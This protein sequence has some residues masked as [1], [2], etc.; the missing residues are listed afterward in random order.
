MKNLFSSLVILCCSLSI[1]A[2]E[3]PS[4]ILFIYDASGSMW[5]AMENKTKKEIASD[6]LISTVGNLPDNQNIGLIAYGHRKKSDCDDIEYLVN[7]TNNTKS[8]VTNAVK[9]LNPTG[10]TPLARSATLAINSLKESNTKATIILITDGKESCDGDICN[11]ITDAKAN[12][13]DFK[14]H[15]VGF[16]LKEGEKEQ[17]KCAALAGNGKYYDADNAGGL[18]DVLTEATTETVDKPKG[19]FSVYAVKNGEPV[20]AWVKPQNSETKKDL[21]GARTYRDTAWVYL[22]T[23]KYD[24]EVKPLENSDIPSTTISVEIKEGEMKH[25]DVSFDGGILE[26]STTTNGEP[27]DAIVKMYDKNTGKVIANAR[28]YGRSKQMEVPAGNYKVTYQA[29]N[30]EGIDIYV[31]VNDVEVQANTTNSISHD[32]KSGIVMIGVKTASGELIDATV[33]F[34]EINT[35]KNVAG[36]RTYTSDSSNPKKFILNPGTYEVKISTVG[37]HKGY[38]DSFTIIVEEGKTVE[39]SITF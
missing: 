4:P 7:L 38:K 25:K 35:R 34:H 15:I 8:N 19:N 11:V 23:G 26:V 37:K 30:L 39:K 33:N 18:G 24:I 32:F 10:R 1:N 28:T 12:G 6:V 13:I 36:A 31:E 16:G 5:G 29:L 27:W 20:D 21:S 14:L 22:P 2:Q 17:L 9:S 3:I